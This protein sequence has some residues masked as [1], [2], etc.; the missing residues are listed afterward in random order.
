MMVD[1]LGIVLYTSTK[2][3]FGYTDCYKHT[4]N[5]LIQ[6]FPHCWESLVRVAHIKYSSTDNAEILS[7]MIR[8]L[9]EKGFDVLTSTGD[10]SHNTSSHANG[11]YQ[12]MEKAL[13]YW[14]LHKKRY[15]LVCEDD[16]LLNF[17]TNPTSSIINAINL[18]DRDL[19]TMCVRINHDIHQNLQEAEESVVEG[20]FRQGLKYTEYGP[21]FT[22]QPTI[23]RLKEWYHSVRL[24]NKKASKHET[25]FNDVHCELVSGEM[26]KVFSDSEKPFCFFDPRKVNAEHIGEEDWIK[27]NK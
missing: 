10:W 5:R 21:T 6:C 14:P 26:L 16:W 3:H 27:A 12:D 1:D 11:Y 19:N 22:F 20:I 15:V 24:I 2:G 17:Q 23:V 25:F 9:K 4:V 13:G 18:M 8:F 7:E